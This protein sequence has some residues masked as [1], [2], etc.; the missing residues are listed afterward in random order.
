MKVEEMIGEKLSRRGLL[1]GA[2]GAAGI[3]I[4]ASGGAGIFSKAEAKG[5]STEK[6]PWPYEKLDPAKTAEIATS[7]YQC[8][9]WE[10]L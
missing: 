4:L 6:W 7:F 10:S 3:A 9:R 5:G 1:K 2:A 8:Y